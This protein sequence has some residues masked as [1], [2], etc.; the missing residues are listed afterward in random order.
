[1][2]QE[3]YVENFTISFT[4]QTIGE[5][6]KKKKKKVFAAKRVDVQFSVR[7]YVMT[8]K[9]KKV[10]AYQSVGFRSQK[11]KNKMVTSEAGLPTPLATP[12]FTL[13][14]FAKNFSIPAIGVA[15]IF[16]WKGGGRTTNHI[17]WRRQK[18]AKKELLVILRYRRMED[19]KSWSVFGT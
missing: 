12:L 4:S 2:L 5:D 9:K 8:K 18:L 6:Q 14:S 19:Q 17:Q 10:F 3:N 11:K 1:M 13:L 7:K 15:R 16:D